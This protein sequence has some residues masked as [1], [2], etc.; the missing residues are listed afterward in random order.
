MS[1]NLPEK[2]SE[3]LIYQTEDGQTR[4]DVRL[5][6]ETVWLTQAAMAELYQV[7]PQNITLHVRNI[8]REGELDSEAT[9]KEY[10]QVRQEGSRKIKRRLKHYNLDM[11]ISVGYRVKSLI[12]TRFRIWATPMTMPVLNMKN[13]LPGEGN[14][15]KPGKKQR[16]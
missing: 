8:Y 7:T 4:I 6:S 15:R 2:R 10:L 13:S 16:P 5:E 11:I 1:S 9:C 3:I 12:G 14:T